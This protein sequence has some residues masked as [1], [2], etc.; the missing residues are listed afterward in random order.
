M[1]LAEIQ[2]LHQAGK[3][4]EAKNAYLNFLTQHPVDST[5]LH[6][7]GLLYAEEG[8]LA[9]AEE[10]LQRAMIQ[11]ATNASIPL[12]LANVFKAKKDFIQAEQ[13]LLSL[14]K[15]HPSFSAAHN[16][17]GTVYFAQNKF[18]E[19]IAAYQAAIQL[20]ANYIDAYY[21]LGLAF[22]RVNDTPA[23]LGAFQALMALAPKHAAGQFQLGR[24]LLHQAKYHEAIK[25]FAAIEQD[26]PHHFE[27]QSNLATCYLKIGRIKDAKTHYLKALALAPSD[28]QVLFNLG[29]IHMQQDLVKD[30]I[31]YYLQAAAHHPE[32]FDV[33][34][35]LG[36]A[37]MIAKDVKAA[38][39]EFERASELEPRNEA[40]QHVLN[41][42]KN[43]KDVSVSPQSYIR[44]LFD[45]YADHYDSHLMQA[46]QYRV[47]ALFLTEMEALHF[48]PNHDLDILDLGCGT[49]L[50]G[51]VF[52]PYAKKLI[53]VD[54]SEKMLSLAQQK[55]IYD[56]LI[57]ADVMDFLSQQ[58]TTY[59]VIIAGDVVVYFGDLN[60]FFAGIDRALKTDGIFLF[61]TEISEKAD[62]VMTVTGRFA[63]H[64]RYI[65]QLAKQHHLQILKQD[66]VGMRM[67][68]EKPV[69]GYLYL[70]RKI[71][72]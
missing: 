23:A 55:Q 33:H 14:I 11:D 38:T 59:D 37:Y 24:L 21:N 51:E 31:Q 10:Y 62:F 52:K 35:N 28:L 60:E 56:E 66:K 15:T 20:Q 39:R 57:A 70:L 3:L 49:G 26:H 5:A 32:S 27:T 53:G 54:L 29:V 19:A 45:S 13:I 6:L 12:H 47:P 34:N 42:L 64:Q 63:H 30:A 43:S 69:E 40:V 71:P 65:V 67:Q 48:A 61:N 9:K 58:K 4:T 68:E 7:L 25:A 41:I 2:A 72:A 50:C 18:Y 22:T 36:V 16:N 8:D 44:T 46:L 17:I 1:N